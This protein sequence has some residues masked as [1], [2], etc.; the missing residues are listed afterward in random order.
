[1][2]DKKLLPQY[3]IEGFDPNESL[4]IVEEIG[5]DGQ[6]KQTLFMR[7]Q[8]SLAWFL[9][10]YPDGCLN[11]VFN[12]LNER[13]AT[14]TAS[15]YRHVN[16]ARPA[17]TATCT[18]FFDESINGPYYEQN[19]V[20]AAYRKALG[21]LGFGTPLDAHP[22]EGQ[23]VASATDVIEKSEAGVEIVVPRP[24]IRNIDET[25]AEQP[26]VP[27][28]EI[29]SVPEVKK[30]PKSKDTDT[31]APVMPKTLDEAKMVLMPAGEFKGQ[32]IAAAAAAKGDS[33]IRWWADKIKSGRYAGS[34]FA[35]AVAIYCEFTGC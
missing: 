4:T 9:T 15:V 6:P 31:P 5:D 32:T 35:K 33:Y 30:P 29:P 8:E 14:V 1:M 23:K 25:D 20:T 3:E 16:D 10:I 34:P 13:K 27:V 19:A 7:F 18:R 22:T 21:Y 28:P 24:F 2:N 17:A 26:D 12:N 11:H